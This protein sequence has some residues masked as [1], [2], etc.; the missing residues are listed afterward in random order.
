MKKVLAI[1]L[2]I[3]ISTAD[4]FAVIFVDAFGANVD[5]GD[6][7]NQI[8]FGLGLGFDI[9]SDLNFIL[10]TAM[11]SVT[12][13]KDKTTETEYDHFTALAGIEYVP[14][15]PALRNF[16][17]SWKNSFL[18]GMSNSEV[19]VENVQ[20]GE[21]SDMGV[22]CAF[23]TGLQYD[24]TQVISPFI[25]LGYHSSFYQNKMEDASVH[26]YQ[27]AFGIRFYLTGSRDYTGDYQ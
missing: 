6:L 20:D 27:V 7:E 10:R 12:E 11:T 19:S 24:L 5:A 8:G 25:D 21:V 2:F 15:I 13:D 26:G 9:N 23:W 1:I 17:M 22:A 14:Q 3:F 4:S 16:K 18:I